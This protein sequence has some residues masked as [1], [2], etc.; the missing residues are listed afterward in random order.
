MSVYQN[1]PSKGKQQIFS[2][3][4]LS[5]HLVLPNQIIMFLKISSTYFVPT[6]NRY[7]QVELLTVYTERSSEIFIKTDYMY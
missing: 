5:G 3:C 1:I 2:S 7:S 6:S 4:F